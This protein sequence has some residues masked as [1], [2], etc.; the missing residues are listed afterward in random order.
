[1]YLLQRLIFN[2]PNEPACVPL[3]YNLESWNLLLAASKFPWAACLTVDMTESSEARRTCPGGET[4]ETAG[5]P[6]NSSIHIG[7]HCHVLHDMYHEPDMADM[8]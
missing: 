2:F 4:I 7:V 3:V 1:M 6:L 5:K 8:C